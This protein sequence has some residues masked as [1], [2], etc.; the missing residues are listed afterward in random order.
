M[1]RVELSSRVLKT[2]GKFPLDLR[3]RILEGLR[4]LE[5]N[6]VPKGA[7]KMKGEKDVYRLRIGDYRILYKILKEESCILVFKV[8][9]RKR[10]YR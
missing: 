9:H 8:E 7:L 4:V 6:A 1:H 10:V 5:A 2:L 3:E